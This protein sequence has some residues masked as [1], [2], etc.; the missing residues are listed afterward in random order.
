MHYE[1]VFDCNRHSNAC[2]IGSKYNPW[3]GRLVQHNP[4]GGC[5]YGATIAAVNLFLN[6][7]PSLVLRYNIPKLQ[8]MLKRMNRKAKTK[9]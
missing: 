1:V 4:I 7:L 3:H 9:V 6:I 2:Y 8:A 5:M